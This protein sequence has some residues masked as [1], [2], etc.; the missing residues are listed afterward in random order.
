VDGAAVLA[1]ELGTGFRHQDRTFE[2][3]EPPAH[4]RGDAADDRRITFVVT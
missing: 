4:M 3:W 1:D 2:I